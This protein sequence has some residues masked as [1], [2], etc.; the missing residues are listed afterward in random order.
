MIFDEAQVRLV[1]ERSDV[2][3]R[4]SMFG[5]WFETQR[6][7]VLRGTDQLVCDVI[8]KSGISPGE[9]P[10]LRQLL[11]EAIELTPRNPEHV[12]RRASRIRVVLWIVVLVGF[13]FLY[14]FWRAA[15]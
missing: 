6:L 2:Y 7:I 13:A 11:D 5:S 10:A 15:T 14:A 1:N 8:P 4:W 12:Q 9:L 3:R